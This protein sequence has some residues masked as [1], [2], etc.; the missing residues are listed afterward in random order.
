MISSNSMPHFLQGEEPGPAQSMIDHLSRRAANGAAVVTLSNTF[1]PMGPKTMPAPP[2]LRDIPHMPVYDIYDKQTQNRSIMLADAI[3]FYGSK[4]CLNLMRP[5]MPGYAMQDRPE[6][7]QKAYPTEMIYQVIDSY[8]QQ[9]KVGKEMGYD[10]GSIHCAYNSPLSGE[11]LSSVDNQRTDEFG[12]S[13]ENRIR[14][15]YLICKGIKE[16]CGPNFAVEVLVSGEDAHGGYT[17]EDLG[18]YL[19]YIEPYVDLVQI[20][21]PDADSSHPTGFTPEHVPAL[22]YTT[23][24]KTLGLDML[25]GAV[26]GFQNAQE[27]DDAIAQGKCDL[28]YAA[29][30]FICDFDYEK[31]LEQGRGEDITPCIRCNKCHVISNDSVMVT[32]CSVNPKFGLEH[33]LDKMVKPAQSVKKV[34]VVGGGPA[35]MEAAL[36]AAQRGHQVTLYEAA[37]QLGGALIAAGMPDFK[38]PV[39][40]FTQWMVSQVEKADITVKLNTTAT[41]ELLA[42]EGYDHVIAALGGTPLVLPISGVDR[43]IPGPEAF[44]HPEKVP[45][46]VVVIGGGEIGVEA[47]IYFARRGQKVTVLEMTGQFAREANRPHYYTTLLDAV[48]KEENLTIL[49]NA[50]VSA[51]TETGVEY[52]DQ[53]GNLHQVPAQSVVLSAGTR[54]KTQEALAFYEAGDLLS[55]IGDC[56]KPASL[57]EAMRAGFA[58]ASQI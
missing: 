12:G 1:A 19:K 20:R 16:A 23:Y 10:I 53:E 33:M 28:V 43:A 30:A 7:H 18:K 54:G 34:A 49:V 14:F 45:G 46:D 39:R 31:K 6:R 58:T 22:K 47:G 48:R 40:D 57:M 2:E 3:H 37:P 52:T 50:K 17:V 15:L 4:A 35:G 8:I 25:I 9:A 13:F 51:V 24:L 27:A 26:G 55:V 32:G 44:L 42:K 38:W 11:V 41:P 5:H 29:R 21:M 36:T 56:Q